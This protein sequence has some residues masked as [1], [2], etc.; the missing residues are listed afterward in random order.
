MA[1]ENEG[2]HEV[3]KADAV[4]STTIPPRKALAGDI[5][6]TIK[7]AAATPDTRTLLIG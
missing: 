7:W 5:A 3:V 4:K 2:S 6:V 1:V